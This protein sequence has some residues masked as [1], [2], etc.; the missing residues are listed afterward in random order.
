M[1]I[2]DS[3]DFLIIDGMSEAS[4]VEELVSF[5]VNLEDASKALKVGKEVREPMKGLLKNLL[6]VN[7]SVITWKHANIV[8]NRS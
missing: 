4:M 2:N 3:I 5:S 8:G 6:A 1:E 7:L